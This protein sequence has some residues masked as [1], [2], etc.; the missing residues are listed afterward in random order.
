MAIRPRVLLGNITAFFLNPAFLAVAGTTIFLGGPT[1]GQEATGG[2]DGE[3]GQIRKQIEERKQAPPR[4]KPPPGPAIREEAAPAAAE[5]FRFVLSAVVVE[6]STVF[7]AKTFRPAYE[8]YLATRITE[9]EAR[10]IAEAVTRIYRKAGYVLSRAEIPPQQIASGVLRVRVVEG[11]VGAVELSGARHRQAELRAITRAVTNERPVR[12]ETI[13]RTLLLIGDRAGITITDS[14]LR[15]ADARGAHELRL[16]LGEDAVA[17]T[18]YFDNRGTPENGREQAWLSAVE[19]GRLGFGE[20]LQ[21]SLFTVPDEPRELRY[22]EAGWTQPVGA[23]G[24]TVS[25]TLALSSLDSGGELARLDSHGDSRSATIEAT[26]PLWRTRAESLW[27]K[28]A[29]EWLDVGE[30]ILGRTSFDDRLRSLRLG[31]EY[32]RPDLWA[33]TLYGRMT[34]SRG[35]EILGASSRAN[36]ERSRGDADAGYTKIEAEL[37]RTQDLFGPFKLHGQMKGQLSADPLLSSEEFVIGGSRYGRAY[38]FAEV[39]GEHGAAALVEMQFHGRS[40]TPQ[41]WLDDWQLYTF[42][43]WGAVYRDNTDEPGDR[44]SLASAGGGFRLRLREALFLQFE[45]AAPLTL[46]PATTDDDGTRAFLTVNL[47]L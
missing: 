41:G 38:D 14:S 34:L 28:G 4:R 39:F 45:V 17:G 32:W 24:T 23:S 40:L 46:T 26:H 16:R 10:A 25:A 31:G 27:L 43:D 20:R 47:D 12:L 1:F 2:G 42:Y 37:Q 33:G 36:S 7:E 18:V 21:V 13:E 22:L 29:F 9:Q 44:V 6:G 8:A 15:R 5:R 30:D 35:L 11:Y 3:A 19:N